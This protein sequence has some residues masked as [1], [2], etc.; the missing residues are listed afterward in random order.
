MGRS[1]RAWQLHLRKLLVEAECTLKTLGLALREDFIV[2]TRSDLKT[3]GLAL[4]EVTTQGQREG[5]YVSQ[6]PY[7][8]AL[9]YISYRHQNKWCCVRVQ[10]KREIYR[11]LVICWEIM[12]GLC[13]GSEMRKPTPPPERRT[14]S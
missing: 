12:C 11:G 9:S 10:A 13:V 5:I 1:K 14:H 2:Q 7:Y 6:S 4:R 3:L 8:G